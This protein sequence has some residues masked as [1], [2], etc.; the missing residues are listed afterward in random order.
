M[1]IIGTV[2]TSRRRR[3]TRCC[4]SGAAPPAAVTTAFLLD[5]RQPPSRRYRP[6]ETL[7]AKPLPSAVPAAVPPE[8]TGQVTR[9]RYVTP[10]LR[11]VS[12]QPPA[13]LPSPSK[14]V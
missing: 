2:A 3:H 5:H 8:P 12:R 6:C 11:T 1:A 9:R 13:S 7:I 10:V 4:T 14:G